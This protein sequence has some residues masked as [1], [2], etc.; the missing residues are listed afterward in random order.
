[1]INNVTIIDFETTGL[2]PKEDC[3]I[4]VGAILYSVRYQATLAQCS[5]LI[6]VDANHKEN[7]NKIKAEW[8]QGGFTGFGYAFDLIEQYINRSDYIVAHGKS[9]DSQ[10]TFGDSECLLG[11]EWLCTYE[12]FIWP[13]N[14][15]PCNLIQTAVNHGVA[16]TSAHRALVDCQLIASLFDRATDLQGLFAQAIARSNDPWEVVIAQVCYQDKDKPKAQ[17]FNWNRDYAPELWSKKV[18]RSVIEHECLNWDF[19]WKIQA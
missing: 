13:H 2:N 18:K 9:F 12:D 1:M 8:T 16:V 6:P 11:C 19:S 14:P 7:I 3:V 10:W 5:T 17:G 15:K 4:E